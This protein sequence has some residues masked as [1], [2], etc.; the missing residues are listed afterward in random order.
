[1]SVATSIPQAEAKALVIGWARTKS[2]LAWPIFLFSILSIAIGVLVGELAH[3]AAL[4][5]AVTGGVAA[6]LSC[7]EVLMVWQTK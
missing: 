7:I 2:L 1:M 3:N 6:V 5:V 4:G